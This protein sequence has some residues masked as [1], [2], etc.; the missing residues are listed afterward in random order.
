MDTPTKEATILEAIR[1]H[2]LQT[3]SHQMEMAGDY[4]ELTPLKQGEVWSNRHIQVLKMWYD[5]LGTEGMLER[6]FPTIPA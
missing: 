3:N 5:Q 2:L 4:L 1:K 6:I